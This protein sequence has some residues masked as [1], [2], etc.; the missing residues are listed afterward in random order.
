MQKVNVKIGGVNHVLAPAGDPLE[1]LHKTTTSGAPTTMLVGI[2][3][4]HPTYTTMRKAPSVVGI[5]ASRDTQFTQ[6]IGTTRLQEGRVE[7]VAAM[8]LL[9][10]ECLRKFGEL[11]KCY[12]L[13][14][15]IYRDGTSGFLFQLA[16]DDFN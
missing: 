8:L 1:F 6:W 10:G 3:V 15:M 14:I 16:S 9:M 2:D 5:V 12:P 13:N 11:H 7:M 4:T